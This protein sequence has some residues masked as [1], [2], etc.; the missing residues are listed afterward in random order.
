LLWKKWGGL[1]GVYVESAEKAVATGHVVAGKAETVRDRLGEE[2]AATGAD[3]L[4][5]S[6]AFGN[7]S[8]A[9]ALNSLSGFRETVMPAL[10]KEAAPAK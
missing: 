2:V 3:Y 1:P 8:H 5:V 9:Q 6:M 4:M 7:L 10:A